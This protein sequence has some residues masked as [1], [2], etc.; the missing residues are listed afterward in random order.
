M[1][2][3]VCLPAHESETVYRVETLSHPHI[4][5]LFALVFITNWVRRN[6]ETNR[7]YFIARAERC[8][9]NEYTFVQICSSYFAYLIGLYVYCRY[10]CVCIHTEDTYFIT[11]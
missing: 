6:V 3:S 11:Y 9:P 5:E 4:Q 10:D 8:T 7:N 1:L 2:Q